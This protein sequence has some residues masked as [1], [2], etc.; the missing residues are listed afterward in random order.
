MNKF[1]LV[2]VLILTIGLAACGDDNGSDNKCECTNTVHTEAPCECKAK[3]CECTYES[4][5]QCICPEGEKAHLGIGET[6]E[7][8]LEECEL[9]VYDT[10]ANGVKI[11]RKGTF[12]EGKVEAMAG[13]A[14]GAYESLDIALRNI[15]DAN[16]DEIH[17]VSGD[18]VQRRG[19]FL[20]LGTEI[21][22]TAMVN[23]WFA[24][25][26]LIPEVD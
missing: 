11:H 18:V 4:I 2:V 13:I 15:F 1:L 8:P 24:T 20:E 21:I 9:K 3:D 7:C 5:P 14:V 6:C 16:F 17:I 26:V 22:P 25:V 19:K 12:E 23:F 10:L